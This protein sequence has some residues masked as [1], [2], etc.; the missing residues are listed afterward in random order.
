MRRSANRLVKNPRAEAYTFRRRAALA[1]ALA[2]L[3]VVL[4]M[5][6][7]FRLQ[8]L[9]HEQYSTRAESNRIK[10]RPIVPARG[11]IFDRH[12]ELLADNRPAYRLEVI[13]EQ[14]GDMPA[15]LDGLS[16]LVTLTAD[17]RERFE[18]ARGC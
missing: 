16:E 17:D 14:V 18:Q 12:G 9:E 10:A 13:P 8:A 5:L 1:F 6:G 15:L 4:M 3:A 7:Y 11:L 2:T